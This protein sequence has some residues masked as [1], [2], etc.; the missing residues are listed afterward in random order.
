MT[1]E[2]WVNPSVVSGDWRDVIYKGSDNYY[3]MGTT[4]NDN[5]GFPAGNPIETFCLADEDWQD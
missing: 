4:D 3:L 5:G 1:L 2:A